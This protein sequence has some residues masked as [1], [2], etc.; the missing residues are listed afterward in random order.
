[1]KPSYALS[2]F[3]LGSLMSLAVMAA[4]TA[5]GTGATRASEVAKSVSVQGA[6]VATPVA[7]P[8]K[9]ATQGGAVVGKAGDNQYP[10]GAPVVPP[11]P[12]KDGVVAVDTKGV[13][14]LGTKPGGV[15]KAVPA[16]GVAVGVNG[17]NQYPSGAPVVPPKPKKDGPEAAAAAAAAQKAATKAAP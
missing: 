4:E 5:G 2:T 14:V 17:D 3:L 13:S 6:K 10:S 15:V 7:T 9:L 12:K 1:M 8:G 16:T 11:K